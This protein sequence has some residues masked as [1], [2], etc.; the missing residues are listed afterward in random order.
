MG[1]GRDGTLHG[2]YESCSCLFRLGRPVSRKACKKK[3]IK[4]II[5]FLNNPNRSCDEVP[6]FTVMKKIKEEI[7]Q[8]K[9]IMPCQV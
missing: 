4:Q 9:N 7:E 5:V 8:L 2:T 1:L 3:T 6:D